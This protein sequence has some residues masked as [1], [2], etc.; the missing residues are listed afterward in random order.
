MLAALGRRTGGGSAGLL[1]P[2]WAWAWAAPAAAAYSLQVVVPPLGDS[3][4]DGAIAAVLKKAGDPV[5]ENEVIAQI[6]TDK[7]TIDIKAPSDG[8]IL[9]VV[10]QES[11][12]VVPGQLVCTIDDAAAKANLIGA[13]PSPHQPAAAAAA[14]AADGQPAPA[15]AAPAPAAGGQQRVP[16][17]RFPPRVTADGRR[18]SM[19]PAA[20]ARAVLEAWRAGSSP[21]TAAA[22]T[23]AAGAPPGGAAVGAAKPG[24]FAWPHAAAAAA[25]SSPG[26]AKPSKFATSVTVLDRM[27]PRR[28]LSEAELELIELGG[29]GP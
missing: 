18:V 13:T 6:E 25:A 5:A 29:A 7:V 20:E 4:S 11:E 21:G 10:V 26:A 1:R 23:A 24:A 27:P 16:G 17:I 28:E 9:G 12:T 22:A 2:R 14:A 3:I 19:L 15:A 8:T